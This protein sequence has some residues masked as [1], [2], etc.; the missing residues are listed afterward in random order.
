LPSG[1]GHRAGDRLRDILV[2]LE[3][4]AIGGGGFSQ[5]TPVLFDY[6]RSAIATRWQFGFVTIVKVVPSGPLERTYCP[7][8]HTPSGCLHGK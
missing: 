6:M 7:S 4:V 8:S 2:D 5:V 1:E 3:I